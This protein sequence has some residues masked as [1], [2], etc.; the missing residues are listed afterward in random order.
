MKKIIIFSISMFLISG[1]ASEIN[2]EELDT[3]DSSETSN[4]YESEIDSPYSEEE[5]ENDSSAPST[6]PNDYNT[7]GEYVPENGVSDE[8]S[9]YN[10]EGEYK[11]VDD[12]T[13]EEIEAELEEILGESLGQ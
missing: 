5:L 10:S 4:D 3:Y 8:P 2:N 6:N 1:C 12:M 7:E 9:D 11:P 13:Q